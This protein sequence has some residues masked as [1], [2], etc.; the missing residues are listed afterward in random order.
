[1]L[2]TRPVRLLLKGNSQPK[3]YLELQE[4][5]HPL[6]KSLELPQISQIPQSIPESVIHAQR[7]LRP[8]PASPVALTRTDTVSKLLGPLPRLKAYYP[9]CLNHLECSTC[10]RYLKIPLQ[11]GAGRCRGVRNCRQHR[12]YHCHPRHSEW[13]RSVPPALRDRSRYLNFR[14]PHLDAPRRGSRSSSTRHR[15]AGAFQGCWTLPGPSRL[16]KSSSRKYR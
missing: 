15:K 1:M 5:S 6:R 2:S 16:G 14:S 9:H 13:R 8:L 4:A 10:H 12:R 7:I 3:V 11:K